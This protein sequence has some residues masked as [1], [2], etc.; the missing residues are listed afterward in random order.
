M[1]S[2][3]YADR[4]AEIAG[5]YHEAVRK[6]KRFPFK[7]V[8]A[9]LAAGLAVWGSTFLPGKDEPKVQ[10]K[11]P[12]NQLFRVTDEPF[13]FSLYNFYD[14]I[15]G[16]EPAYGKPLDSPFDPEDDKLFVPASLVYPWAHTPPLAD[17]K[18]GVAFLITPEHPNTLSL[19]NGDYF[20]LL[21]I[22]DVGPEGGMIGYLDATLHF[23]G[24]TYH[25]PFIHINSI[26]LD[27]DPQV[28]VTGEDP[29]HPSPA[30]LLLTPTSSTR[31]RSA[32]DIEAYFDANQNS[33]QDP[34]ERSFT[35]DTRYPSS[36]QEPLIQ[37]QSLDQY[38]SR[39][40]KFYVVD[41]LGYTQKEGAWSFPLEAFHTVFLD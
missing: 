7:T 14:A 10:K 25:S 40:G 34:G 32:L 16:P 3:P 21:G 8:L 36:L 17:Y 39:G 19:E 20:S 4:F 30:Y 22:R 1:H 37:A 31:D 15:G 9:A 29:G 5:M 23:N 6:K 18:D 26:S 33:T 35:L 27:P 41:H 2:L 12:I 11:F 24:E 38:L 13:W 28:Y